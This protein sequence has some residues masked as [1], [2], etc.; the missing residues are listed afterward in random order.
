MKLSSFTGL[1]F[2]TNAMLD[3]YPDL[4]LAFV[5]IHN[6]ADRG[7]LVEFLAQQ[8]GD[9]ADFSLLL[10]DQAE[11]AAVN[12]ALRDA[13]SALYG[14]ER[15]TAGLSRNGLCLVVAVILEAIQQQF[16][17]PTP[18]PDPDVPILACN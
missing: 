9:A 2:E 16:I 3:A 1:A 15:G 14:R 5:Q 18:L 13:A 12:N 17:P 6:A 8:F 4:S 11:L 10:S 7:R